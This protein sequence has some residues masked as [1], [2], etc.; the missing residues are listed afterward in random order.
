MATRR[1]VGDFYRIPLPDRRFA[2]CQHV[3]RVESY[4][5]VVRVFNRLTSAPLSSPEGL[6]KAGLLFPPVFAALVAAVRGKRWQLIGNE[7]IRGFVLPKFRFTMGTKPG[8]YDDWRIWDE[9]K[10]R[11]VGKLPAE[12]RSLELKCVWGCEALAER[13]VA[14]SYRGDH[15]L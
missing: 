13:I 12:L 8:T 6:E 4:G 14:E 2:Y 9:R 3:Y 7:P 11:R 1:R 10:T 15:M 5:D